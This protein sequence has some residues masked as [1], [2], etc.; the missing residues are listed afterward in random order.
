M[1]AEAGNDH[2]LS[3]LPSAVPHTQKAWN[4]FGK[5]AAKISAAKIIF[6]A[7][8]CPGTNGEEDLSHPPRRFLP[9]FGAWPRASCSSGENSHGRQGKREQRGMARDNR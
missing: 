9:R 2:Y 4:V 8:I 3:N 5:P 7:A 6:S 1:R